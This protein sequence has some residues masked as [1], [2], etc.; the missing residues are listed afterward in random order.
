MFLSFWPAPRRLALGIALFSRSDFCWDTQGL[1]QQRRTR[2]CH[3]AD[4]ER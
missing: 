1:P 2:G 4:N 3:G